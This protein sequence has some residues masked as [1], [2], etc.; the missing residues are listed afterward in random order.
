MGRGNGPTNAGLRVRLGWLCQQCVLLG[1]HVRWFS[2]YPD[3]DLREPRKR[4]GTVFEAFGDLR[5]EDGCLDW[6]DAVHK[7]LLCRRPRE[8]THRV[9]K[10]WNWRSH[11][12][13]DSF[14]G[15]LGPDRLRGRS[16][17]E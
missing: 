11:M 16:L 1:L 8:P 12:A 15:K 17:R 5:R 13:C 4:S 2:E 7:L 6:G 3:L 14:H 10:P 9:A